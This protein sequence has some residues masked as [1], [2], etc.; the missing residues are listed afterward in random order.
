[1]RQTFR[2]IPFAHEAFMQAWKMMSFVVM[3]RMV[4]KPAAIFFSGPP[5]FW[6]VSPITL[7]CLKYH[8]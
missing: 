6:L 4:R 7:R 5:L 1:M 2:H 8:D 3:L